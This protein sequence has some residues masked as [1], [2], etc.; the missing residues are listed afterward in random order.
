MEL[1][2]EIVNESE[3]LTESVSVNSVVDAILG[4]HPAWIT[5]DD[6]KGGGGKARRSIYPIAYGLTSAGNPV[7]RAFQP[8]G[9]SKRG[10]TT[11]PNNREYPKWKY[12]RLD[13]IKFW[14]TVNSKT[15]D[16]EDMEGYEDGIINTEGDNSMSQVYVVAPFGNAKNIKRKE[17]QNPETQQTPETTTTSF[18][19]RPITKDEVEDINIEPVEQPI[20]GKRKLTALGAMDSVI[21]FIKKYGNKAVQGIKNAG[22]GIKNLFKKKLENQPENNNINNTGDT[23][24]APVTKPVTKQEVDGN[25]RQ[26]SNK[27]AIDKVID[28]IKQYNNNSAEQYKQILNRFNNKPNDK[29][30]T[31]QDVEGEKDKDL[32]ENVLTSSFKDMMNRMNNLEK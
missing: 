5:Y 7:V 17:T 23:I 8:I 12:F 22:Q 6:S 28:T 1:F 25:P 4:M 3:L 24:N 9:S 31:K 13:R 18:E 32:K 14:R 21:G 16:I 11:P 15:Y 19:P 27:E 29:P 2:E 30:V 10:L 20:N 26:L